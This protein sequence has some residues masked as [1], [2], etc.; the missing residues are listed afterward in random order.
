LVCHVHHVHIFASDIDKSIKFYEEFFG[1][2]V[3][4]DLE[5]AGARNVFMESAADGFISMI[6]HLRPLVREVF[7][8][9]GSRA[10]T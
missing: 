3:I 4:L 10:T 8:I 7:I 1:G 5:L 9:L 2:R 6:N